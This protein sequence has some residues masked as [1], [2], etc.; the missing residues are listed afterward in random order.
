MDRIDH[1][2]SVKGYAE[3]RRRTLAAADARLHASI[4]KAYH[5]GVPVAD[6]ARAAGVERSTI[7]RWVKQ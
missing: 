4:R 7:Y 5:Q 6:L 2:A 1:L 3:N